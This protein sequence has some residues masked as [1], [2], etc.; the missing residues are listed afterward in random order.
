MHDL[1]VEGFCFLV[2]SFTESVCV[3]GGQDKEEE[4]KQR[5]IPRDILHVKIIPLESFLTLFLIFPLLDVKITKKILSRNRTTIYNTSIWQLPLYILKKVIFLSTCTNYFNT[6]SFY[7][8]TYGIENFLEHKSWL[9]GR[10]GEVFFFFFF[11]IFKRMNIFAP[12][13]KNWYFNIYLY[14]FIYI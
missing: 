3:C 4:S 2:S 9:E 5:R 1:Q 7:A 14:I 11:S 6:W 13:E 8:Q 12:R 10:K